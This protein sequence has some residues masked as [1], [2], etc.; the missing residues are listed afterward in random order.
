MKDGQARIWICELVVAI[1]H[2]HFHGF[3]HR[4]IKSDNGEV[5]P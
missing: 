5:S 2:L 4:D 1:E 3:V